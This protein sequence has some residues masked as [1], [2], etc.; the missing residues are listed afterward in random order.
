MVNNYKRSILWGIVI[1]TSMVSCLRA[2][3][4]NQARALKCP[5]LEWIDGKDIGINGDEVIAIGSLKFN[6][7]IEAEQAERVQKVAELKNNNFHTSTLK[8]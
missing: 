2:A 4:E 3:A 7:Q 6:R 5:V 8:S 1:V